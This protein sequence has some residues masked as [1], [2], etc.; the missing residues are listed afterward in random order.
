[1]SIHSDMQASVLW[2]NITSSK[3]KS[4]RIKSLKNIIYITLTFLMSSYK[5]CVNN[6]L[7]FS[8]QAP[9]DL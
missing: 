4:I 2:Y 5:D 6:F 9:G 3:E 7:L 1:M 8:E